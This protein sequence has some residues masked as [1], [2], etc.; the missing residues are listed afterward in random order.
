MTQDTL[1]LGGG[2]LGLELATELAARDH[3]VAFVGDV[4]TAERAR[5]AGLSADESTLATA[6]PSVDRTA[7]TVVVATDCDARNLLLAVAA[8]RAF[9]AERVVALVND[10]ERRTAFEDAGIET[11]CVSRI[12]ARAATDAVVPTGERRPSPDDDEKSDAE[13]ADREPTL[14]GEEGPTADPAEALDPAADA[15]DRARA[16]D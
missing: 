3:S 11:V 12:V 8:P 13:D 7:S 9:G 6:V 16:L 10:P 4:A 15:G 1:V 2:P 14:V 5:G